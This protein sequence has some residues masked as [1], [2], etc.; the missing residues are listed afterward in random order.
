MVNILKYLG[1]MFF[2][3]VMFLFFLPKENLYYALQ[4]EAQK[5]AIG[6]IDASHKETAFG[7]KMQNILLV[8]KGVEVAKI[9]KVES[10]LYLFDNT[11][12]AE[13]VK[14]SSL[15]ESYLPRDVKNIVVHYRLLQ[16]LEASF[17]VKG[18][19]GVAKGVFDINTRE[20]RLYLKPSKIFLQQYKNSLT[21]LK[22]LE[23]GEYSYEKTL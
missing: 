1:Y 8:Y 7:L 9:Q 3:I 23:N 22:K 17:T 4:K 10:S 12:I 2:F 19:F 14:L 16:P 11:I 20:V 6:I 21:K 18:D 13:N 5:Y 15:V